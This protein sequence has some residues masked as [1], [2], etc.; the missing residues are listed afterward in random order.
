MQRLLFLLPFVIH[1][2]GALQKAWLVEREPK[3]KKAHRVDLDV[4]RAQG[5][6]KKAHGEDGPLRGRLLLEMI[7]C[8][9][10][11]VLIGK[12]L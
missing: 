8:V 4:E 1:R 12:V 10:I 5:K 3:Q 9:K 11:R 7:V 2:S 6:R